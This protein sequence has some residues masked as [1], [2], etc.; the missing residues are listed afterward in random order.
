MQP[1]ALL[2][3]ALLVLLASARAQE[4]DEASLMELMQD[5]VQHAHKAL[6]SVKDSPVAQ[7]ARDWMSEG[8]NSLK[9]YWSSLTSPLS[10]F[11]PLAPGAAPGTT[12]APAV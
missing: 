12:P 8:F 6:T 3:A 2:V 11:W 10:K 4:P 9:D 7:Q 5:Y 1:R